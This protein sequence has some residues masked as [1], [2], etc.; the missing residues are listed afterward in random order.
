MNSIKFTFENPWFLLLAIPMIGV[1]LLTFFIIP[2]NRRKNL[3]SSQRL[4]RGDTWDLAA[5]YPVPLSAFFPLR[6]PWKRQISEQT[7]SFLSVWK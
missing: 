1:I 6:S 7:P 5:G 3:R 2:K 4:R